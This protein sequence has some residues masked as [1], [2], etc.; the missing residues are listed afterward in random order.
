ML[1]LRIKHILPLHINNLCTPCEIMIV[2]IFAMRTTINANGGAGIDAF[3]R[4][5]GHPMPA[6]S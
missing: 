4:R 1:S 2:V 5:R 6:N 3:K